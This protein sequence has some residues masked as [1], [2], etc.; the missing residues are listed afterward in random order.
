M[1]EQL[2][3]KEMFGTF[4]KICSHLVHSSFDHGNRTTILC[5][6]FNLMNR[7]MQRSYLSNN[8]VPSR[9]EASQ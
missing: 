4:D 5:E 2:D 6:L 1:L 3:L 8:A 9:E 7:M